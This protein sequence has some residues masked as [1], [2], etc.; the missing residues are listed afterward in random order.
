VQ[1]TQAFESGVSAYPFVS[2]HYVQVSIPPPFLL[3]CLQPGVEQGVQ[4][5]EASYPKPSLHLQSDWAVEPAAE[6]AP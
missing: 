1:A 5:L 6:N 2:K 4:L 3:Q